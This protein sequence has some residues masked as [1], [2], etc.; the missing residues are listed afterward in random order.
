MKQTV[1]KL[2]LA[3]RSYDIRT[4]SLFDLGAKAADA[5]LKG[6]VL[7]LSHQRIMRL[8]GKPLLEGLKRYFDATICEIPEGEKSKSETGLSAVY[9]ACQR[10]RLEKND[11]IVCFGGGVVGDLGGYAAANWSRGINVVQIPTTVVS[12]VD[13]SIGGKT[14]IDW[15][16]IKNKIGAFKQP[17][18]VF[19]DTSTLSTLS[20]R[21]FNNGMAEVIKYG[22]LSEKVWRLLYEYES[23]A[24]RNL[25]VLEDIIWECANL[26]CDVVEQDEFDTK[27]LRAKLNLGHTVGHAI[28]GASNFR[29]LHGEAIS[30]GLVAAAKLSIKRVGFGIGRH[31]ALLRLLRHFNLPTSLKDVDKKEVM[32]IM[33]SD[34]KVEGGKLRFILVERIGKVTF[35]HVVSEKEVRKV[36]DRYP[37]LT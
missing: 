13:S 15:K 12:Q 20:K 24:A 30:L 19:I 34:K 10:G 31:A 35:P 36:L 9:N 29:L 18:L 6:K 37:T 4:G 26:K 22:L 11:T 1:R 3:D 28:E 27:G 16:K 14:G 21:Q 7:V 32:K 23:I 2:R 8:H 25:P 5:D 33:L 17:R